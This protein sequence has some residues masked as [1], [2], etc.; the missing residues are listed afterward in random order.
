MIIYA[1]LQS[2]S[3]GIWFFRI[4]SNCHYLCIFYLIAT[5]IKFISKLTLA[6]RTSNLNQHLLFSVF[7]NL[8]ETGTFTST[9]FTC[10]S[11]YKWS[12]QYKIKNSH[13]NAEWC[14]I[15]L[16]N[17]ESRFSRFSLIWS[18]IF[19][20]TYMYLETW[21]FGLIWNLWFFPKDVLGAEDYFRASFC[22]SIS[23]LSLLI[24]RKPILKSSFWSHL[25]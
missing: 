22:L 12:M 24:W 7:W 23:T 18:Q 15:S 1:A 14:P 10:N 3:K 11:Q 17:R 8:P 4:F 6:L 25:K 16:S 9:K 5:L 2:K 20:K 13:A 21:S 19:Q